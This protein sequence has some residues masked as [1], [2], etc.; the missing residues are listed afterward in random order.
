MET[1][2]TPITQ[3]EWVAGKRV[4]YFEI[5]PFSWIEIKQCSG[6]LVRCHV[7][8]SLVTH[9]RITEEALIKF[10]AYMRSVGAR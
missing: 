6:G 3:D 1:T 2:A 8:Y 7:S 4:E 10:R 5:G 9:E